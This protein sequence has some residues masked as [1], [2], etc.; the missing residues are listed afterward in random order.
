[1]AGIIKQPTQFGEII[2]DIHNFKHL[3]LINAVTP[4]K[5]F[6]LAGV[7]LADLFH[8][9]CNRVHYRLEVFFSTLMDFH[10]KP[11]GH[12]NQAQRGR[13][14]QIWVFPSPKSE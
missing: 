1:M 12:W 4:I 7:E 2:Y 6:Y 3:H 9:G 5:R 10:S 11:L 14:S 8:I 13:Y